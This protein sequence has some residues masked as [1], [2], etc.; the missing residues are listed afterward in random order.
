M[1][2]EAILRK[3]F[4]PNLCVGRQLLILEIRE[5]SSGLNLAAALILNQN[6]FLKIAST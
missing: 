5:Y 6:P 2:V 1:E 4:W 3:A